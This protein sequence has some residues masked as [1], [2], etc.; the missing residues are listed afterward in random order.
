[1]LQ[2][3][4]GTANEIEAVLESIVEEHKST[5]VM[6]ITERVVDIGPDG[7]RRVSVRRRIV[8]MPTEEP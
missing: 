3:P 7:R 5:G 2:D 4:K 1:M 6:T 8:S